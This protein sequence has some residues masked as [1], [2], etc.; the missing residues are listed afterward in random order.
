MPQKS[1]AAVPQEQAQNLAATYKKALLSGL[2][3]DP[4]GIEGIRRY[5]Q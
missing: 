4:L 2:G 3:N 1:L 5:G